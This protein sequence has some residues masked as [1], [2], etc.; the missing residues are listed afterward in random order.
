M[1]SKKFL[2]NVQGISKEE[3]LVVKKVI[4]DVVL[5]RDVVLRELW[6]EL[7]KMCLL[8]IC[9]NICPCALAHHR[10]ENVWLLSH[11]DTYTQSLFNKCR[12]KN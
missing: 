6:Q 9:E 8:R 12:W 1:T 4:D 7:T 2:G 11:K 5:L 3:I 10:E